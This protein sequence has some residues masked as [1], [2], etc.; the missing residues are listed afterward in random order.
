MFF[1]FFILCQNSL[2][3]LLA[4]QRGTGFR[5]SCHKSFRA[6]CRFMVPSSIFFFFSSPQPAS[7]SANE[8]VKEN[9][10]SL[11][12]S[13]YFQLKTTF[14]RLHFHPHEY[15]YLCR[16]K[17]QL[18]GGNFAWKET[19]DLAASF[20][21]L[22][23]LCQIQPLEDCFCVKNNNEAKNYIAQAWVSNKG[24]LHFLK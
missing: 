13:C 12:H 18:A 24:R 1:F 11:F 23:F 5:T 21:I 8:L 17:K 15:I 14:P 10:L 19:K 2:F 16:L 9:L 20:H 22:F 4:W 6:T 7:I 3:G